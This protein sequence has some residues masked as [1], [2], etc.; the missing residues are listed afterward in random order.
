MDKEAA[1]LRLHELVSGNPDRVRIIRS[2]REIEAL[3]IDKVVAGGALNI[4]DNYDEAMFEFISKCLAEGKE[5]AIQAAGPTKLIVHAAHGLWRVR[6]GSSTPSGG[7]GGG[8]F[9]ATAA[10]GDPFAPEVIVLSAF[11]D[12]VLLRTQ[13]GNRFVRLYYA[14]SPTLAA[15]IAQSAV[16]QHAARSLLVRPAVRLVSIFKREAE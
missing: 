7:T 3:N 9:V 12:D 4:F 16:L 14:V 1:K 5:V 13:L 8:C 6:P 2:E 11:R 10:C 15:L